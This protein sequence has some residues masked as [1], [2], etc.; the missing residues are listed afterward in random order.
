M[1]PTQALT[2]TAPQMR[3]H[4]AGLTDQQ[5]TDFMAA[6]E[7]A[8]IIET[9]KPHD[10]GAAALFYATRLHWPVFPLQPRGKQP[11]TRRGFH[12]ATLDP[13]QISAWWAKHPE[14]N[15]ATPTGPVG[16]GGC[17]LDV[18][19]VDGPAG[20]ASLAAMRHE[21]CPPD[22]SE[23]RF[24]DAM[25]GLPP[26]LARSATSRDA[27]FHYWIAATG[28]GNKTALEPGVDYRGLGGYVVI[29]PSVGAT[30]R[31]YAWITR[32]ALPQLDLAGAA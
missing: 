8:E 14:A 16:H 6:V 27:G 11:L 3:E 4:L 20:V 19:D 28:D 31:R 17:G 2:A 12:D 25:A 24:C 26:V 23:Q 5:L 21:H 9:A 13:E 18:I 7:A 32:P 30:G 15:I 10:L 29:P 22:C 1:T